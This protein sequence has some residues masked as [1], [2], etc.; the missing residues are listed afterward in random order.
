MFFLRCLIFSDILIFPSHF[1][2]AQLGASFLVSYPLA[3]F[4][5]EVSLCDTARSRVLMKSQNLSL[6]NSKCTFDMAGVQELNWRL[7][8]GARALQTVKEYCTILQTPPKSEIIR[9][10]GIGYKEFFPHCFLTMCD[11]YFRLISPAKRIQIQ[12]LGIFYVTDEEAS[13]YLD[14]IGRNFK[15]CCCGDPCTQV[16]EV[17]KLLNSVLQSI[18]VLTVVA[19]AQ[20]CV[21]FCPCRWHFELPEGAE[22]LIW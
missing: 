11:T 16:W 6:P 17:E 2:Q 9:A 18:A 4:M 22:T 14:H 3:S 15:K 8:T 12:V 20:G 5:D 13:Q 10:F 7:I 19:G 21:F 1:C